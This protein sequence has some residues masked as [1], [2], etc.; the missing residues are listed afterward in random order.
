MKK[1]LILFFISF[2]LMIFA[3]VPRFAK[4]KVDNT[5]MQIYLPTEPKWDK[6][7]T[8]DGSEVY[9]YD[10]L[11]GTMNYTAIIIKISNTITKKDPENLLISYLK[12]SEDSVF[13]LDQKA[14][15]GKG[16]TLENQ[17]NVQGILQMGKNKAGKE[18]KILG[19]TDGKYIAILATSSMEEMNYNIQEMFLRG[20]RFPQ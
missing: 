1:I 13:F 16:H 19:W 17:A 6:S 7:T 10:E 4:Y 14:G 5:A 15:F 20:I 12:F 8:G 9:I 3:Q 18:Y 2:S 11:F